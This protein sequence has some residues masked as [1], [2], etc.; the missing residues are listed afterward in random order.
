M[1]EVEDSAS[2]CQ[3]GAEVRVATATKTD[4]LAANAVFLSGKLERGESSVEELV[5]WGGGVMQDEI[6]HEE[7]DVA[8]QEGVSGWG[9]AGI[10]AW[11]KEEEKGQARHVGAGKIVGRTGVDGNLQGMTEDRDGNWFDSS[12][13]AIGACVAG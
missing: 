5:R 4:D 8:Q 12:W 11:S 6:S 7:A 2:Q 3:D 13:R 10:F 9:I 1:P